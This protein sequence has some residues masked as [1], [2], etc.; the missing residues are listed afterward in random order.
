M[1]SRFVSRG[2][3]D[4][5]TG[6]EVSQS[7][8]AGEATGVPA[9]SS[10]HDGGGRGT[11]KSSAEWEAVQRELEAERRRRDEARAKAV[12]EGGEQSLYDILQAN[13]AAKQ[14]AFEEQH[15]IR[16]QFRALDDDEIDFLDDVMMRQREEEERVKRETREGLEA[17]RAAQRVEERRLSE[18]AGEAEGDGGGGGGDVIDADEWKNVGRKRKRHD[19]REGGRGSLMKRK[20][21]G[22]AA[23][24]TGDKGGNSSM[25]GKEAGGVE[26]KKNDEDETE[27][28]KTKE[29]ADG[30]EGSLDGGGLGNGKDAGLPASKTD[31]A[32]AAKAPTSAPSKPGLGLVAYGSDSDDD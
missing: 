29:N 7:S 6:E 11:G 26:K 16:N 8:A 22:A 18:Q 32:P 17:F 12:N 9:A 23:T 3:I 15:K 4:A 5:E 31:Q 13:K 25:D 2:R 19:R 14:A 10:S 1:A 28:G 21:S 20:A 30:G 24:A 27:T